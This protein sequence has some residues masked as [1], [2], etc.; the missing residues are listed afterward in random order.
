MNPTHVYRP[1]EIT[2]LT[3]DLIA[4]RRD[5]PGL[6]VDLG[7]DKIDAVM[8]PLLPGELC[9][10]LARTSNFKTG[11][12]QY[13]ARYTAKQLLSMGNTTDIV[14]YATWEMSVEELGLYELS[15]ASGVSS[16][17]TWRGKINDEQMDM[18]RE[19]A[20][21]RLSLPLFIVG[22]SLAYPSHISTVWELRNE[23]IADAKPDGFKPAAVFLDYLQAITPAEG[24]D[25]RIQVMANADAAKHLAEQ[26]GCPVIVGVQAGRDL[27]KQVNMVPNLGSSQETSRVEQDADLMIGLWMPK[28]MYEAGHML[29]EY[30][31]TVTDDLLVCK[32]VKQRMGKQGD[33]FLLSVNPALREVKSYHT[34]DDDGMEGIVF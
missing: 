14:Y 7:I 20:M 6:T 4:E 26:L 19:A 18:Q 31:V 23:I 11:F 1:A 5:H 3:L 13:W 16:T 29:K 34:I 2:R 24:G 25:R 8:N 28:M 17:D 30:N 15:A 10:I 21:G 27:D 32:I 12:M 9:V 22:H 33:S